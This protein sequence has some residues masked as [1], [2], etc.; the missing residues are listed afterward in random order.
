MKTYPFTVRRLVYQWEEKT[1]EAQDHDDAIEA[2]YED[3]Q[4]W[5][6]VDRSTED[7]EVE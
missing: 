6:I 7:I 3:N 5:S 1:V 2:A 4:P